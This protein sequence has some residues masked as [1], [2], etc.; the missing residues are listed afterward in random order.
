M[1]WWLKSSQPKSPRLGERAKIPPAEHSTPFRQTFGTRFGHLHRDAPWAAKQMIEG[2][3]P[4]ECPSLLWMDE[5]LHQVETMVE[6]IVCWYLGNH[7]KPGLLR[8]LRGV[9]FQPSTVSPTNPAPW[10]CKE[11]ITFCPKEL[12]ANPSRPSR[13]AGPEMARGKCFGAVKQ[14]E[15]RK[16]SESTIQV[17]YKESQ[18][19]VFTTRNISRTFNFEAQPL[20]RPPE[21]EPG[22]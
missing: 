2:S 22:T 1:V 11:R 6:T 9:R 10:L 3:L 21:H 20:A 18:S 17:S 15:V 14:K 13:R 19:P 7:Q 8:C 16:E 5:I 4:F 12:E